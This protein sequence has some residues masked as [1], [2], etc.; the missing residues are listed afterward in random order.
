MHEPCSCALI[1]SFSSHLKAHRWPGER[2][3]G[4]APVRRPWGPEHVASTHIKARRRTKHLGP[5]HWGGGTA[6][7]DRGA[8]WARKPNRIWVLRDAVSQRQ[9]WRTPLILLLWRSRQEDLCEFQSSQG[10]TLRPSLLQKDN[11][12]RRGWGRSQPRTAGLH[13]HAHT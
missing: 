9:W 7:S 1:L 12:E 4:E 6:G 11:I 13:R 3:R 2:A 5:Q 8:C 10:C